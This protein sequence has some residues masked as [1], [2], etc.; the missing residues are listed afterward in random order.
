[1]LPISQVQFQSCSFIGVIDQY[2]ITDLH[3]Q[4]SFRMMK[5]SRC[6]CIL[7]Q[8]FLDRSGQEESHTIP[9]AS[10]IYASPKEPAQHAQDGRDL[11]YTVA[12]SDLP[13]LYRYRYILLHN[14]QVTV[15]SRTTHLLT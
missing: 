9:L 11:E 10:Q 6:S 4:P 8:S 5:G 2:Q 15:D 7:P 13:T 12:L 14:A 3:G 1:M